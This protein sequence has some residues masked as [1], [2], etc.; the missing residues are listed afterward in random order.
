MRAQAGWV[1]A[2]AAFGLF[3]TIL[4][5]FLVSRI[6]GP[7]EVGRA[8]LAGAVVMLAQ[9]FVGFCF[10][11]ALV[12]RAHLS[13]A[14]V[15]SALW[16]SLAIA[17]AMLLPLATVGLLL[18]DLLGL[19][20]G[21]VLAA[22]A[23]MLPFNA[24]EGT[25][26][27]MLLRRHT[28]RVLALRGMGAHLAGLVAGLSLALAGWG[29]WAVVGQQLAF[30][31]TAA[32]L[33][34]VFAR[35]VPELT[36]RPGAIREMLPFAA[37]AALSG[38]AGRVGFRL[39]LLLVAGGLPTLAGVLQIAF[40]IVEVARELP[41]PFV[42][43]YGLPAL[44]RLRTDRAAF[45]SRLVA[46][47]K[48]SGL[49][50]A[51][52]FAGLALCA[53]EIQITLLGPAWVGIVAPVQVLSVALTFTAFGLPLGMAFLAA[54]TPKVNL[55]L[56]LGGLALVLV[57]ALLVPGGS[58]LGAATAWAAMLAAESAAASA[59]AARRLGFR[60]PQQ[61]RAFAT[62][63]LPAAATTGA[64]LGAEA[65]GVLPGMPPLALLAAKAAV[66]AVVGVP[67]IL[68]LARA[69]WREVAGPLA[70]HS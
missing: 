64:V 45:L 12:Q 30:F 5:T 47:C 52:V 37:T 25:A 61:L 43:R 65:A 20:V 26:N 67:L 9:P 36:L 48:L 3:G 11:N 28:F 32:A 24:V 18:P 21:P 68:L 10:T 63:L 62:A 1:T 27:G 13:D 29:A 40:R 19:G 58:G 49:V 35:L 60:V 39:F 50:F 16:V 4:T 56:T 69:A 42:H 8:A 55:S 23:L 33:A 15:A 6:I 46:L 41:S 17:L 54:G 66:G 51:P 7:A 53:A 34:A 70:G 44:S 31:G 57:L 14:D 38:L 2:E 22:L 59:F